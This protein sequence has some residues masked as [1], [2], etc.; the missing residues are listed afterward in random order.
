M[1]LHRR[2]INFSTACVVALCA[3]TSLA[4]GQGFER[5]ALDEYVAEPDSNYKYSVVVDEQMDGFR[6]V[7][8]DM[9]SQK[10]LTKKEVNKPIWR[11]WLVMA[12]PDEVTSNRGLLYISGG[13][14]EDG[15][16][17]TNQ[18]TSLMAT[19]TNTVAAELRMVPNQPLTFKGDGK[20]RKEDS[21]IAFTWDKFLRTGDEKWPLRLPMT[22]AAVR[23]MDTITAVTAG[24][25]GGGPTVDEFVVAGGSKRGWTTWTTAAVDSRVIAIIPIVIDMLNISPSFQHLLEAYG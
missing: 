14:N 8:V 19:S 7:V 2:S 9:V 15:I 24:L 10:W 12:I 11:H 16:P 5:T 17:G 4:L 13:D 6:H 23:A 25:D 18:L 20:P 22:K 1:R 21:T 3:I